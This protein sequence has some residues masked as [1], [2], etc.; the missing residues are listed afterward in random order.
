MVIEYYTSTTGIWRYADI[1]SISSPNL[2]KVLIVVQTA[3][4]CIHVQIVPRTF[5]PS[6]F[7]MGS[8]MCT[9]WYS[10]EMSAEC[11]RSAVAEITGTEK[12]QSAAS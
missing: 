1:P 3:S 9:S 7:D 12:L 4:M 6:G 5:H 10:P 2:L 11:L 8:G